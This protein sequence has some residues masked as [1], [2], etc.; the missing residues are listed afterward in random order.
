MARS[1]LLRGWTASTGGFSILYIG[2]YSASTGNDGEGQQGRY[3]CGGRES[4][5]NSRLG[6]H[7]AGDE[8]SYIST[9]VTYL[10]EI[11]VRIC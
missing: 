10:S 5:G 3:D 4:W 8:Y 2:N 6:L 1:G 9:N 11:A 7:Q